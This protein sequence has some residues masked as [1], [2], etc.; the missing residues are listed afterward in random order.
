MA[1]DSNT[2]TSSV[3]DVAAIQQRTV[4]SLSAAAVAGGIAVAGSIPAGA[5]IAASLADEAVAGLAQT[6]GV[7]GAAALA[8]PLARIAL[9]RGRRAAL[10]LG[11]G[12][13]ALGAVFVVVAGATRSLP[14]VFLGSFFVGVAS[15]ASLQ[16]RYAATD[17]A[18]P[19]HRAR[20]LAIVVWAGTVGAV[21]GP[22]LLEMSGRAA[23]ELGLP[24][25]TGPYLVAALMFGAS[26]VVLQLFMRPDPYLLSRSLAA[27]AS[28]VQLPK[29][30][31]RDGLQHLRR[32]RRAVLGVTSVSLGHVVMVMVMVM[33]PVH[34]AH[35]DVSL[36]LIGLV[37]SVHVLGMY[38]FSPAVGWLVDR[39]GR[40]PMIL[41]GAAI[42]LVS[43]VVCGLAPSDA[44]P[45]LAVGLFL[46][47]LGW[48]FTLI[49]GSTLV[50]DD[51][52]ENERP[53]VQGLS[54][55]C[56]NLAAAVGGAIA[57]FIVAGSSYA[58]LCAV[59]VVPVLL[60]V[61]MA[62]SPAMRRPAAP[63]S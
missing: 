53:S 27:E 17:L 34:M 4:R 7:I 23:V 49:A 13:G 28:G 58:V 31:L 30:S 42:L 20:A 12:L 1:T 29:A 15:A 51:V 38:A 26:V 43:C 36:N 2:A 63:V 6:T 48:S 45:V 32:H 24:Q 47:G 57:G 16:A 9:S 11:Y 21:L 50:S 8:L 55:L 52:E 3:A 5:L 33:T 25:L 35:V 54:D 44:V 14:L 10:S 46:L 59:A 18:V 62:A 41:V 60:L 37:I 56:M 40:V 39:Y 19:S 61:A 22:N